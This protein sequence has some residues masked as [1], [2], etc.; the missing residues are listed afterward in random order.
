MLS[1]PK[2]WSQQQE[3]YCIFIAHTTL[4]T[5]NI[6][7]YSV[8][9]SDSKPIFG[10]LTSQSYKYTLK[11]RLI[12]GGKLAK[13]P[14]PEGYWPLSFIRIIKNDI[15]DSV[16]LTAKMP[17]A[18]RS[19]VRSSPARSVAL[20]PRSPPPPNRTLP[21][22]A[23][24]A[25]ELE[26]DTDDAYDVDDKS[27]IEDIKEECDFYH[28]LQL[29]E[30]RVGGVTILVDE[31]S[32]LRTKCGIYRISAFFIIMRLLSER[33]CVSTHAWM[34][35]G[36]RGFF[37]QAASPYHSFGKKQLPKIL[38]KMTKLYGAN[39][40]RD[41]NLQ[42][43]ALDLANDET[44]TTTFFLKFPE[45]LCEETA[46]YVDTKCTNRY[47]NDDVPPED[48]F[49]LETGL[50]SVSK[51]SVVV[52]NGGGKK[53]NLTTV[54]GMWAVPIA[55]SEVQIKALKKAV[56]VTKKDVNI[57]KMW[58]DLSLGDDQEHGMDHDSF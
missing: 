12:I 2:D 16:D 10:S 41:E 42:I 31:E 34:E 39:D 33:D 24:Y 55:G 14:I 35:P 37:I 29:G 25:N 8:L 27:W 4:T 11:R 6:A 46:S 58:G 57:A 15:F 56:A 17:R 40:T 13:Y 30:N 9:I 22:L 50:E 51:N 43:M 1:K 52:D 44:K 19:T 36:K 5:R 23:N 28:E 49:R 21:L 26:D 53:M 3:N 54:W 18:R 48:E 45:T 7:R 32:S 47:L 38:E 20:P